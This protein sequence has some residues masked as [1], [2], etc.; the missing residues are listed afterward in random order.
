M[1]VY[2]YWTTSRG[3][4]NVESWN[5]EP[6]LPSWFRSPVLS[7]TIVLLLPYLTPS[8]SASEHESPYHYH[9]NESSSFVYQGRPLAQEGLLFFAHSSRGVESHRFLEAR[10]CQPSIAA[11]AFRCLD[12]ESGAHQKVSVH[13]PREAS[14]RLCSFKRMEVAGTY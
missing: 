13:P 14:S 9:D 7:T 2:E 4:W 11:Q 10:I 3:V 12:W 1:L 5:L 8:F 6:Y